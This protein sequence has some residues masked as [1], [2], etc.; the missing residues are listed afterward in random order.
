MP[1][2][3]YQ[4]KSCGQVTSALILKSGEEKKVRCEH[5]NDR[6]LS[7]ILSRF[8]THK[9]E[10]QRIDEFD[11]RS[12]RGDEFYK[13]DRNI[14]L[15]AQKRSKEL[16]VDLGTQFNNTLERARSGKIDLDEEI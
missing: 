2:Y 8:T 6:R 12:P 10:S 9:P 16:G 1:L 15:W 4:C 14:G 13:D 5:C 7:R 3:E 11:T